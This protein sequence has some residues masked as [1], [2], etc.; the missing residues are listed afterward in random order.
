MI[1]RWEIKGDASMGSATNAILGC[2][3]IWSADN[4]NTRLNKSKMNLY[5]WRFKSFMIFH[6]H[7][8]HDL[9]WNCAADFFED[10]TKADTSGALRLS[11]KCSLSFIKN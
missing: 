5:S 3:M 7:S 9:V 10:A 4:I 8:N 6:D 2:T 11:G 1:C